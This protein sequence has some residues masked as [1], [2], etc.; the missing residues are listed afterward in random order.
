MNNLE[1]KKRFYEFNSDDFKA[2]IKVICNNPLID[3]INAIYFVI[4][5]VDCQFKS[6]E[7]DVLDDYKDSNKINYIRN[8]DSY[9]FVKTNKVFI[10]ND[11]KLTDAIDN[12]TKETNIKVLVNNEAD[13]SQKDA[14][15][16][17]NVLWLSSFLKTNEKIHNIIKMYA[18]ILISGETNLS[19]KT[20]LSLMIDY[21]FKGT[22][23]II[24][25]ILLLSDKE[26][27][28]DSLTKSFRYYKRIIHV[29]IRRFLDF[30]DLIDIMNENTQNLNID[31]D[32]LNN[33]IKDIENDNLIDFPYYFY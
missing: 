1:I 12:F 11:I 31:K 14:F 9:E 26:E 32:L 20:I 30:N 8:L 5:G 15:I 2:L 13:G 4:Q 17:D 16:K 3:L 29:F 25:K 23:I 22:N 21:F 27:I 33:V 18:T 6:I 10:N 28:Y 24:P 19:I 7:D